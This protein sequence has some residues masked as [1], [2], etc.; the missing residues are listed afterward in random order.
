MEKVEKPVAL[1]KKLTEDFNSGGYAAK[2]LV[3]LD[4]VYKSYGN[5]KLMDDI[6]FAVNRNDSIK[7]RVYVPTD[8]CYTL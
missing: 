3:T 2:Q 6:N 8:L 5:N 4:S 7:F 1:V